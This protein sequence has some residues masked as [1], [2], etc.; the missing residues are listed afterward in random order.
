MALQ[1]VFFPRSVASHV[2]QAI[3]LFSLTS[4]KTNKIKIKVSVTKPKM[5][6]S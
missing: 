5:F 6:S 4:Q 2:V 1:Q 3:Y